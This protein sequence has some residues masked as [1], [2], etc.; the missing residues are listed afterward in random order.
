MAFLSTISPDPDG[1]RN[2]SVTDQELIIRYRHS[3]DLEIL[4]ELYL[5]YMDLLYGV[6]LKYLKDPEAAK[7]AVMN[8]FEELAQKLQKHEVAHFRGWI[9]TLAKN[10]CLMQLRAAKRI[11][12]N[13]LEPDR[14]QIAEELHLNGIKEK[15]GELDKLSKCLETLCS[16]QKQAVELFYLESKCYKEIEKITGVE[17]NKVRSHIQ[18]GKRNLKLCMEKSGPVH[19]PLTSGK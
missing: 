4:A 17:W 12:I 2:P 15:E 6:C 9:H 18:N 19:S 3:Q 13:D 1:S 10:H 14:V 5:R 16:E 7:D 8:I 11:K